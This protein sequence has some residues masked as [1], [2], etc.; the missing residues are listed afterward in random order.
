MNHEE[1]TGPKTELSHPVNEVVS[2]YHAKDT[3]AG[4]GFL[5]ENGAWYKRSS[6]KVQWMRSEFIRLLD[7]RD[8]RPDYGLKGKR[9]ANHCLWRK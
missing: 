8:A 7:G 3:T 5:Q 6:T 4:Q 1:R 2:S 9:L